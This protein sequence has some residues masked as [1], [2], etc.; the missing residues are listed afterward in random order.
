M[1]SGIFIYWVRTHWLG[2]MLWNMAK[3]WNWSIMLQENLKL[4]NVRVVDV[5]LVG[6]YVGIAFM[7]F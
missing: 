4:K 5:P 3:I 1:K 7:G 6:R 2:A